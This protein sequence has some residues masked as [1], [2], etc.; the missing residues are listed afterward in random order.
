MSLPDL[1][2]TSTRS[3]SF[4]HWIDAY[5]TGALQ[6]LITALPIS[7]V[8]ALIDRAFDTTLSA[9]LKHRFPHLAQQ[10]LFKD[11][12]T[13]TDLAALSPCLVEI[14]D[15]PQERLELIT[16]LMRASNGKPMLSFLSAEKTPL[17]EHLHT[18]LEA[19]DI[20]GRGFLLRFADTRA[21]DLL[22]KTLT[23]PQRERL[24][25]DG[26]QWW[27]WRR[28]G[29]LR[30]IQGSRA[31]GDYSPTIKPYQFDSRQIQLMANGARADGLLFCLRK[32]AE[33]FGRLSGRPSAAHR[34]IQEVLDSHDSEQVHDAVVFRQI[35]ESLCR[36][37]LLSQAQE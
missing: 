11:L 10:S 19:K 32:N 8:Y 7:D 33:I 34:C 16:Y 15:I 3:S 36:N 26:L 22:L 6:A 12:Y 27:Y 1:I 17:L 25:F 35:L 37:G 2:Q 5:P 24:L 30:H 18:Q 28:D 31:V 20:Q 14:P 13:G 23:Q 9:G 21:L 4:S 29:E